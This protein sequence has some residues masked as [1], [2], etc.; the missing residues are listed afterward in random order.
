MNDVDVDIQFVY[1]F[2]KI[3]FL[4]NIFR[5]DGNKIKVLVKYSTSSVKIM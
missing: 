5:E 3:A 4:N 1:L 2:F